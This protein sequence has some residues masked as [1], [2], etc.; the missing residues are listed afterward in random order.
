MGSQGAAYGAAAATIVTGLALKPAYDRLKALI[1]KRFSPQTLDLAQEFPELDP[2]NVAR[3]PV[4]CLLDT[5]AERLPKLFGANSAVVWLC[6][7]T[8]CTERAR[9]G[10]TQEEANALVPGSAALD[11]LRAG[12]I[13]R[14]GDSANAPVLVP[15]IV[16]RKLDPDLIGVLALGIRESEK[17]YSQLELGALTDLGSKLGTAVFIAQVEREG[18]APAVNATGVALKSGIGVEPA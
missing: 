10:A 13:G 4:G 8:P 3:V 16:P 15:L 9:S 2:V 12:K 11:D 1:D 17:G 18:A 7:G 6:D 5:V 14:V